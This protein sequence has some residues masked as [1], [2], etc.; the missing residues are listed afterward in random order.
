[1][2]ACLQ[3]ER[4]GPGPSPAKETAQKSGFASLE[5]QTEANLN[6]A[7]GQRDVLVVGKSPVF[8]TR[9]TDIDRRQRT[10]GRNTETWVGMIQDIEGLAAQLQGETLKDLDVLEQAH[11]QL[12]EYG[13][14][15]VVAHGVAERSAK[16]PRRTGAVED[17]M[18]VVR[19]YGD[20][21]IVVNSI[22]GPE[23]VHVD[24][25]DA[26]EHRGVNL[27]DANEALVCSSVADEWTIA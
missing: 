26:K 5:D 9:V 3:K 21:L 24:Y 17:E 10:T 11:I 7:I 19:R 20:N 16:N 1:V 13:P 22:H 12:V 2:T 4:G 8:D 6:Y 27:T 25:W 18:H 15:Q 14:A 23:A